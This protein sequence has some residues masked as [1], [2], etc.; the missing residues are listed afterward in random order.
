MKVQKGK[1]MSNKY[2][3]V[4]KEGHI[5]DGTGN[6][7]FKADIGIYRGKVV[8]IGIIEEIGQNVINADGM[9]VSPGFIDLHNHSDLTIL[10][11]PDCESSI[12][13]GMTTAV[14]GN[15]GFSMAPVSSKN[16]RLLR[17]YISP[18]LK[19]DFDYGWDWISLK[20]YYEKVKKKQI[21]MN[22][23]PL[24]GHGT[25]RIAVRGF[26][27]SKLSR[28]ELREMKKLL[29]QSLEDG[30]FGMSTGLAYPPGYFAT[31]EELLE[32]GAILKK[33]GK[34]YASH[35]RNESSRLKEAVKEA[36]KIGEENNIPIEISHYKAKGEENWGKVDSSLRLMEKARAKG[37]EVGCDVYPYT[38][39]STTITSI[40]PVWVLEGGIE[41][42]LKRLRNSDIREKIKKEYVEDRVMGS[43]DIK[44]AGFNG[45]VVSSCSS[46]KE[47]E[48]KSLEDIING[49][50]RFGD[51][52]EGL[53]EFLLEIKGDATVIKF[54]MEEED[55]KQ[56][57]SSPLSLIISDS[58][59]TSPDEGGKPHPR[60]YGTFP[61][62]LRIY[63]TEGRIL[64]IEEAI[65]KI[66]SLP[67]SR[68]RLK[69]RGLI[70]EGFWADIVLFDPVEIKDNST[71][72]DPHRYP[73]GMKYVIVNGG[74]AVDNGKPT[75]AKYGKI[76]YANQ[77]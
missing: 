58:W 45:I 60:A 18:F 26:E 43:N 22:L 56:V 46:H 33:Y 12:M 66:T 62:F 10:A 21:A 72:Q 25:I 49:K 14:V 37:I 15:C 71:Y 5:I 51:P 50:Y 9:I 74:I 29:I 7:W 4:V 63:V 53:F 32:L 41:K 28:A 31:M 16:L 77:E 59:T 2:D 36:I 34:I 40:L 64:T 19:R 13:Q 30:A 55:V 27:K 69:G 35:I 44:D 76:I 17:E 75:Y 3:I 24:V 38:A 48:G 11:H 57:I 6:P 1:Q 65:R 52:Y 73:S 8:K 61:R 23:V 20:D 42:M 54:L 68:I 67:A 47:Y 39:G 70:K